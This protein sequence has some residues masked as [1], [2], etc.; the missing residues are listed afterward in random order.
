[1][2][3]LSR[4]EIVSLVALGSCCIGILANVFNG[5]GNPV[6]ASL[7]FSGVAFCCTYCMILWLASTFI[8]ANLKGKD[9]SKA[10]KVEMY[11]R[12]ATA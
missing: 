4:T 9:L 11:V 2:P 8:K 7:A 12:I 5:D 1:M 3:G 10:K 6:V